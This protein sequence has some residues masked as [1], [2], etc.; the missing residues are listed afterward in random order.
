MFGAIWRSE[1]GLPALGD[2][3]WHHVMVIWVASTRM[4]VYVLTFWLA[5]IIHNLRSQRR[6]GADTGY[7]KQIVGLL[8]S[9]FPIRSFLAVIQFHGWT[10]AAYSHGDQLLGLLSPEADHR[11]FG[12][13][14]A[15]LQLCTDRDLN[16]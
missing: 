12:D 3:A 5:W 6:T 14:A 11:L 16:G 15:S 10:S 4:E 13:W 8:Q 2:A 7:P 1:I 9:T